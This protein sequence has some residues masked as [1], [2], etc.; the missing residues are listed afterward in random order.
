MNFTDLARRVSGK[1][2]DA[3]NVHY[4]ALERQQAGEDIIILSVGQESSET[5]PEFILDAARDSLERGRHHY[6]EIGGE[7]ELKQALARQYSDQFG[8][9]VSETNISV[10][11]GAQNAL[12]AASLCTLQKG[13]DVIVIEPYYATYPAT[14]TAGGANLCHVTTLPENDFAPSFDDI[15]KQ[16][17]DNTRA[18][19]INSPHNPAGIVY[20]QSFIE[21]VIELC[22][23]HNIWLIS[24]EVYSSL[25]EPASFKSPASYP[26]AFESCIT[27]SSVSKSHRMTG[28]RLGWVV[29]CEELI[30]TMFN[31][32]LCMSYGL[33]TFIQDA[34]VQAIVNSADVSQQVRYDVNHKRELVIS[35]LNRIDGIK[36]WGS[37]VGMFVTFDVRQTGISAT[38]F[39]WRLL[40]EYDVAVLPCSAFGDSGKGIIRINIG[41]TEDALKT[42]CSQ[43]Q[44]LLTRLD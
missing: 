18:I 29:A 36:V 10:F 44:A 5:T 20:G 23:K 17:T 7:P 43:I 25:V 11:A 33:P 16:L 35:L 40:D 27:V 37:K 3:W 22:V 42:A 8:F 13:D 30:E 38:D 9:A 15:D 39:A 32:S 2:A 31:L 4:A 19:V 24:D 14:F 6:S 26:G 1:G 28:W 21:Q 34:C 41:D 12:F